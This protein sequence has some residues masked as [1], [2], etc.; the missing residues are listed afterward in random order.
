MKIEQ[1]INIRRDRKCDKY[2]L[3]Y[4]NMTAVADRLRYR[5]LF[6][7]Q[8]RDAR[9]RQKLEYMTLTGIQYYRIWRDPELTRIIFG[10][11]RA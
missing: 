2:W 9:E 5:R 4:R 6:K 11:R 1:R 3:G 10:S 7:V 8:H